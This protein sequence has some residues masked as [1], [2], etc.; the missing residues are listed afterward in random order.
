L[1]LDGEDSSVE[2]RTGKSEQSSMPASPRASQEV[3]ESLE[4]LALEQNTLYFMLESLE[5]LD[6][7]TSIDDPWMDFGDIYPTPTLESDV[8]MI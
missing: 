8:S 1:L 4:S 5:D 2:G 3:W 6:I 7:Q